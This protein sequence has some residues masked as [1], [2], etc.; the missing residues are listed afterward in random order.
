MT[1][2]Y[3]PHPLTSDH[4]PSLRALGQRIT[5]VRD[6][7]KKMNQECAICTGM[8]GPQTGRWKA[9]PRRSVRPT[10]R[11][12]ETR[13]RFWGPLSILLT[14]SLPQ[15]RA[16]TFPWQTAHS[17][18]E[19]CV[20]Q[21]PEKGKATRTPEAHSPAGSRGLCG[22]FLILLQKKPEATRRAQPLESGRLG[23]KSWLCCL[24]LGCF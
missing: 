12:W 19:A 9:L 13:S 11:D 21:E 14:S 10:P 6:F 18:S 20:T 22:F 1:S 15:S 7:P 17:S 24:E 2:G 16:T 5:Q 3:P 23:F 4:V 8:Q